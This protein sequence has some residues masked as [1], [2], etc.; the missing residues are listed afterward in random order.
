MRRWTGTAWEQ[1]TSSLTDNK[2][3]ACNFNGKLLISSVA[4]AMRE[5]DGVTTAMVADAPTAAYI[6][7]SANRVFATGMSG[8]NEVK[9]CALNDHY[10]WT[11]AGDAGAGTIV[12]NAPSGEYNTGI[13]ALTSGRVIVFKSTSF[14]EIFGT[15]PINFEM[16]NRFYGIGCIAHDTIVAIEGYLYWLGLDGVYRWGG[17]GVPVKISDPI[18]K[19]IPSSTVGTLYFHYCAGTDGRFY[20]IS[21]GNDVIFAFDTKYGRWWGPLD[22]DVGY[23]Y[24]FCRFTGTAYAGLYIGDDAGNIHQIDKSSSGTVS[25]EWVSKVFTDGSL[26]RDKQ[27]LHGVVNAEVYTGA[28]LNVYLSNRIRDIGDG[29]DWKLIKTVT[30][31]TLPQKVKIPVSPSLLTPSEFYRIKFSWSGKVDIYGIDKEVYINP[32][33]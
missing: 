27:F 20:Y 17:S 28:T 4:D 31:A 14:H 12:I 2:F 8:S 29:N 33:I 10:D 15:G 26:A 22:Y 5:Y 24:S 30:A 16:V 18:K 32:G 13:V 3:S 9:F 23:V 19:Y 25:G 21:L 1:I 6:T 11:T 7:N